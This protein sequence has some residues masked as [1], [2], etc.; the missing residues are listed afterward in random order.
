[1]SFSLCIGT[2]EMVNKTVVTFKINKRFDNKR[3][4]QQEKVEIDLE[5]WQANVASKFYSLS[6]GLALLPAYVHAKKLGQIAN[7]FH[8]TTYMWL[9]AFPEDCTPGRKV[10]AQ[11]T[12]RLTRIIYCG[13]FD[14][15][16]DEDIKRFLWKSLPDDANHLLRHNTLANLTLSLH[17]ADSKLKIKAF[18][19]EHGSEQ[20]AKYWGMLQQAL[21]SF[22]ERVLKHPTATVATIQKETWSK[23]LSHAVVSWMRLNRLPFTFLTVHTPFPPY[24]P[25]SIA[26]EDELCSELRPWA[27]GLRWVYPGGQYDE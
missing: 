12:D 27:D 7:F 26:P 13:D 11:H 24:V 15:D 21:E 14:E 23:E 2:R 16:L 20:A 6:F 5:S 4:E 18:M 17:I 19:A 22:L 10:L 3:H 1:M 25:F 8:Q 9:F